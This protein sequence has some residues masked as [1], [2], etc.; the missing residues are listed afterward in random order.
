MRDLPCLPLRDARSA[1]GVGGCCGNGAAGAHALLATP[2]CGDIFDEQ[3]PA[4]LWRPLP[5]G[6]QANALLATRTTLKYDAYD[7]HSS[8]SPVSTYLVCLYCP[9]MC[10]IS[11]QKKQLQ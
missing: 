11:V 1:A 6:W 10:F 8:F 7:I 9:R 5:L 4:G 3:G 2:V